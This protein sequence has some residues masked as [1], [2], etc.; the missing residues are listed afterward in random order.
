MVIVRTVVASRLICFL[1]SDLPSLFVPT[2]IW[3]TGFI[4]VAV[5]CW[6]LQNFHRSGRVTCGASDRFLSGCDRG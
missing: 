4:V 6:L 2:K 5:S 1:F 3:F